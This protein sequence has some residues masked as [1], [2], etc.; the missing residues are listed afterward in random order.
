MPV[1]SKSLHNSDILLF[2]KKPDSSGWTLDAEYFIEDENSLDGDFTFI[3]KSY[4]FVK[5]G[6]N[7]ECYKVFREFC[8]NLESIKYL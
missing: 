4:E 8:L 7:S 1:L 2:N 5:T 3:N 6:T